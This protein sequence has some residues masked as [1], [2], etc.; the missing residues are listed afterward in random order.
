MTIR[1]QGIDDR[2]KGYISRAHYVADKCTDLT[3]INNQMT[4][5]IAQMIQKEEID[6]MVEILGPD[7]IEKCIKTTSGDHR[8]VSDMHPKISQYL[9]YCEYCLIVDD[10]HK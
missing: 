7:E 2:V 4:L 5:D 3:G 6:G 10:Y 8:F 9:T 1:Q